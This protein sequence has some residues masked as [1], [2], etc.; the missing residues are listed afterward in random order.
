MGVLYHRKSPM[1][2]L[3]QIKEMLRPG[4]ELILETLVVEGDENAVLVPEGRYAKMRNVWFL[5]SVAALEKWLRKLGYN[6]VH[7]VDV[8]KTSVE[9]QRTTDWMRW[10]SL[11]DYLDPDDPEKTLEGYP[12]PLRAVTIASA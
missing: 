1:D 3:L 2:H 10:E 4:G 6:N 11:K 7:T 5:P 9:E 12:A 8:T